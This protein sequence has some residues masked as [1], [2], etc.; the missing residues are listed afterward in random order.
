MLDYI[1]ALT[2]SYTSYTSTFKNKLNPLQLQ[3]QTSST[4]NHNNIRDYTRV[5]YSNNNYTMSTQSLPH[6]PLQL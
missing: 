4:I 3:I 5:L 2:A 1:L 6:K